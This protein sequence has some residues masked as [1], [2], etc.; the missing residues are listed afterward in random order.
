MHN[1]RWLALAAFL[2]IILSPSKTLAQDTVRAR[3]MRIVNR[4]RVA[5]GL[6]PYALN[7]KLSKAAQ[8]HSDDLAQHGISLGHSGSDGSTALQRID[9]SGYVRAG[10]WGGEIWAWA[11][12]PESALTEYWQDALHLDMIYNSLLREFGIGVTP[13]HFG[14][15]MVVDFGSSPNVLPVFINDGATLTRDPKV[16]LTLTNEDAI[17]FG[18]G[19]SRMGR[20][21][22]VQVSGRSDLAD[23]A[24]QPYS[25]KIPRELAHNP[26]PQVV[27]V[28]FIDAQG[29]SAITAAQIDLALVAAP[30][31]LSTPTRTRS[32]TPTTIPPKT[33]TPTPV[34]TDTP[35]P[36]PHLMPTAIPSLSTTTTAMLSPTA[37]SEAV[38]MGLMEESFLP[39]LM[40]DQF[41]P[42]A[43]SPG[44]TTVGPALPNH[45]LPLFVTVV[46]IMLILSLLL[47]WRPRA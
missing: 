31:A 26:G 1:V 34:P 12:S 13:V 3:L 23:A 4:S 18:D 11:D 36:G 28:K 15:V 17:P 19:L 37:T 35:K 39:T 40:P 24:L 47:A 43:L 16:E 41:P 33:R 32:S 2:L 42:L 9:G 5:R 10:G 30:A 27:Y 8:S 38:R 46:I 25:P 7:D 14:Y 21:V 20:A 44:T 45:A 29:R 22:T 6:A